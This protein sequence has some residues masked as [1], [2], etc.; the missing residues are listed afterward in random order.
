MWNKREEVPSAPPVQRPTP[1]EPIV[2][3]TPAPV[4]GPQPVAVREAPKAPVS[5]RVTI[6][7]SMII[8]GDIVSS[9]EIFV[10]GEV[11]GKLELQ[12]GLTVGPNGKVRANIKAREVVVSGDVRG[13]VVVTDKITIHRNGSLI[14]DIKTAGIVIDDG[15]YFKGSIDIIR[16][17]APTK[18]VEAKAATAT[19]KAS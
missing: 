8:K 7:P 16:S 6:G 2:T 9:E 11:E 15:A 12:H 19:A 18:A 10:D 1:P 17:A 5:S 3:S 14:G 4:T 13:N